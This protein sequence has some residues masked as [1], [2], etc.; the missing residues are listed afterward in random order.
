MARISGKTVLVTGATSGIGEATA[1]VLASQRANLILWA[2]RGERLEELSSL[3]RNQHGVEIDTAVVDVRDREAVGDAADF[4]KI[5]DN[6]PHALINN[7]G[8][9]RGS[10]TI[11]EGDLAD[12]D[13]MIDTNIKGLLNVTRAVLPL[14]LEAGRGHVVNIGSTAGHITYPTGNVYSAT[15][16]AVRSLSEGMNLDLAGTP[17]KVSSV[18]PGYVQTEFSTVRFRGDKERAK[19]IYRGFKPLTP[20]DVAETIA[21]VLNVPDYMNVLDVVIVP[22]AQRNIYVVDR[23]E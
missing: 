7:A 9:G 2:R 18:D 16:W 4:L 1:R 20:D 22:T 6:V 10:S 11:Q 5:S 3:L 23:S 8:L 12:W 21:F 17:L 15:K 14:M 13:E 19:Q